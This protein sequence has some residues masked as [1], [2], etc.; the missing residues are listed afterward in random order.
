MPKILAGVNGVGAAHIGMVDATVGFRH[1]SSVMPSWTKGAGTPEGVVTAPIG[2]LFSRTDG[3][4]NTAIYRKETGTGNTGWIATSQ[5]GNVTSVDGRTG[6]VTLTDRYVPIDGTY[7]A[8][9]TDVLKARVTGNAQPQFTVNADGRLEWGDGTAAADT[10]LYRSAVDTLRTDDTFQVG[11]YQGLYVSPGGR[12]AIGADLATDTMLALGSSGS[13]NA[14][15]T[16]SAVYGIRAIPV[17]TGTGQIV[18]LTAQALSSA[19]PVNVLYGALI[20]TRYTNGTGTLNNAISISLPSPAINAGA[21]VNNAYGID[22]AAQKVTGVTTGYAIY[23]RGTSDY[24]VLFGNTG[25]GVTA[26]TLSRL[27][28]PAGTTLADGIT[29]G[30]DTSLYR[31]AA[32]VLRTDDQFSC[33]GADLNQGEIKNV[34]SHKLATPPGTPVEGQRYYDTALKFER[35]YNGTSWVSAGAGSVS[36]V[37]GR[38]GVV[39]LSDLYVDVAGDNMTG[40]LG[41]GAPSPTA[42]LQFASDTTSAGGILFGTDTTLYRGGSDTLKTDDTVVIRR[43]N[44]GTE[45]L[46]GLDVTAQTVLSGTTAQVLGVDARIDSIGGGLITDAYAIRVTTP[47]FTG[48]GGVWNAFGLYIQPIGPT[49][50]ITASYGIYQAGSTERNYFNGNVG[51]GTISPTL[52]RLQFAAGT[53]PADGITFGTD[54]NLYRSAANV[55]STDDAFVSAAAIQAALGSG[56]R[57]GPTGPVWLAGAGTPESNIAAP[58]GSMFSRTDGAANTALYR[59]ETGTGITGWAAV[60]GSGGVTS[61]DART[62]VVTLGDLYVDVTGD[63]MTGNLGLGFASPTHKL[64]FAAATTLVGGISFGTDTHLYRG[65][66][67]SLVT[68]A[69]LTLGGVLDCPDT[70]GDKALWSSTTYTT[71]TATNTLY[72]DVPTSAV[73]EFRSGATWKMRISNTAVT[74]NTGIYLD[75]NNNEIRKMITENLAV[76]PTTPAEGSRYYDTA[77]KVERF[78]N[79][80]TWVGGGAVAAH[81]TTH[82]AGGSDPI[83]G[84]LGIN[85]STAGGDSG[86]VIVGALAMPLSG[87]GACTAVGVFALKNQGLGFNNT[88]VGYD[89]LPDLVA[90]YQNVAVGLWAGKGLVNAG[91]NN[92]AI[93]YNSAIGDYATN[94]VAIGANT[95]VMTDTIAIGAGVTAMHDAAVAIGGSSTGSYDF[96]LGK[97]THLVRVPGML[98]I[99]TVPT[100]RLHLVDDTTAT[101]G[102]LFGTDVTLYRSA[103]NVLTTDD[104]FTSGVT[105]QAALSK[106]VGGF[107]HGPS[108]PIWVAGT[109]TP[110]SSVTAPI[111]SI[112]SRTDGAAGTAFYR[113]ETGVGA[114]GWTAVAGGGGGVTSVDSRTGVVT[115]TDKYL[116]L[117]GGTMAEAA[118]IAL[119]ATTGTKIGTAITQKL[120]FWNSAPV[121]QNTGWS[122]T[123]GY[124]TDKAFNPESTTLTEVARALGTLID[125]MKTY[126]LLG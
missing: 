33:A 98:G 34:V 66:T 92:V 43:T 27:Q 15:N 41:L 8:P 126:G 86:N 31:L 38:T 16:A 13:P 17:N 6:V 29:W 51:L 123:A 48:G 67:A 40:N 61:V 95:S 25:M 70:A 102:I 108:G 64:Q 83:T 71:G 54:T 120:G 32:N 96:V 122:V 116:Q 125:T 85:V 49:G 79:G 2:S 68:D 93:G 50:I 42:K 39:T 11:A 52:S 36:S 118:N 5:G 73:H 20:N 63:N 107:R 91:F 106:T 47:L 59:K 90:A 80:T 65:G 109:G 103:P 55:L 24:N 28:F 46:V 104:T 112:Y 99:G 81:A 94:G 37:D 117:S 114:T 88:A 18:A 78:W 105:V 69:K 89:S 58:V 75:M 14:F 3:S 121:I 23:Q 19:S 56:F 60:A 35:F 22:M 124:T 26:P 115:L 1:G 7:A 76:A 9:A 110:E 57:Q 74:H 87:S 113:K 21:V 30:T 97:T 101:G 12:A 62:G 77:L 10:L 53:T 84:R 100:A 111:G 45:N 119:G 82:Y 4:T 44:A 72:H